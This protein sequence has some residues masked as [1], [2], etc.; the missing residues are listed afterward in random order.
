[1]QVINLVSEDSIEHR[2]LG[3]LAQ[4]QTLAQGVLEGKDNLK[5][6]KLP[7]GREAFMERMENLMGPLHTQAT[8]IPHPVVK[9]ETAPLTEALQANTHIDLLQSHHNPDTGE[10]IVFAVVDQPSDDI[11]KE[12][13]HAFAGDAVLL[14]MMDRQTFELIQ[15]LQKAGVLTLNQP[16][17]ILH[18]SAAFT[19]TKKELQKKQT[20]QAQRYLEQASH[21]QRMAKVLISGDFNQEAHF[22]LREAY[23]FTIYAFSALIGEG[24]KKN[25]EIL[26][27]KFIQEKLIDEHGLQQNAEALF[28][29]LSNESTDIS[30][31]IKEW[32]MMQENIFQEVEARI[33]QYM[34]E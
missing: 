8:E 33:T 28:N 23:E 5:E 26:T 10:K 30:T 16:Q 14:E 21:K 15:R 19:E 22:P 24:E 18:A 34:A 4:K 7:S 31:Q 2:M 9:T 29:T 3:L 25:K 27:S 12:L 11:Q 32:W 13:Q 1:V 20:E 6:M 17:K